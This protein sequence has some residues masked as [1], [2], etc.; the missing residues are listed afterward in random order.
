MEITMA[1]DV[2]GGGSQLDYQAVGMLDYRIKPKLAL[3]LG[4]RYLSVNYR[5]NGVIF[6]TISSGVVFGLRIGLK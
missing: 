3:G 6:D 2:G 1:G 4:W 5:S